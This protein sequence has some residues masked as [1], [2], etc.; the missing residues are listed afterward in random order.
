M[1][2]R[3]S[4]AFSMVEAVVASLILG[5]LAVAALEASAQ[6]VDGR[7]RTADCLAAESFA[8]RLLAEIDQLK[9]EEP[10]LPVGTS[11]IG[12]DSAESGRSTFDDIDDYNALDQTNLTDSAGAAIPGGSGWRLR[13]SVERVQTFSPFNATLSETGLKR[14]TIRLSRGSRPGVTF[15][16]YRSRGGMGAV[17]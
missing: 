12:K 10:S 4:R 14:I 15:V 5:V 13:V 3:T 8:Q 9:Y 1:I 16:V 6:A 2:T 7:L 11:T 17:T